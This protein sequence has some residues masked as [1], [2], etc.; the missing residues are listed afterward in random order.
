MWFQA[1]SQVLLTQVWLSFG[2]LD[3]LDRQASNF[4]C[5]RPGVKKSTTDLTRAESGGNNLEVYMAKHSILYTQGKGQT[6][7]NRRK[8]KDQACDEYASHT[9][10][11]HQEGLYII[12]AEIHIHKQV[13]EAVANDL[14]ER[15]FI[16][17]SS[18]KKSGPYTE[19]ELF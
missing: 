19:H 12:E 5:E 14:H 8:P 10:H 11:Q 2:I 15:A 18:T 1:V 13:I 4:I 16:I 3:D 9:L 17:Q 7:D 6:T